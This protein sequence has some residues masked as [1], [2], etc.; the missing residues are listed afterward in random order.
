MHRVKLSALAG[1]LSLAALTRLPPALLHA[2]TLQSSTVTITVVDAGAGYPLTNADVI[3]LA[4][5]QHRFTDERGQ[6]RLP[7]PSGGQ[8]KLRIREVGYKPVQR[9]LQRGSASDAAPT[10]AM[11]KVAYVIS[12]VT[13]TSRCVT[14]DDSAALALSVAVL[15][16]VRQS[17]EKYV[18]FL[19][20]YPFEATIE[21]RTAQIP[22]TGRVERV[23][24]AN[25][26]F[27]S[28]NWEVPYRPGDVV[29]YEWNGNFK[30]PVLFVSTLGDSVFW[31]HHCFLA[32]GIESYSGTR[33]IRLDFSPSPDVRG[34][35]WEG[36]TLIDSTT[37]ALLRMDFRLANLDTRKGLTRLLGYQTFAS[38]SPYVIIPDSVIAIWWTK[39][40][41][42][43]PNWLRPDVAQSLHI[44]R[45][46]YRRNTPPPN[47]MAKE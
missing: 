16:Q 30:A 10:V 35:D 13:S 37:S 20:R 28:D 46:R 32:R 9:T 22:P 12:P 18:E 38:P 40:Q 44:E 43:D 47:S 6:A 26:K 45:L 3:D 21:R 36:S 39:K 42:D 17:A 27:Q 5:G 11:S 19:R 41:E 4:T 14:T 25:L 15:D 7:W 8:L 29:E 2:K 31:G 23:V 34:P 33:A 24:R 1:A